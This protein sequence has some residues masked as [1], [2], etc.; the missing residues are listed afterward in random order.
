MMIG[1]MK[2]VKIA[3]TT[4]DATKLREELERKSMSK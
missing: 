1:L 3:F 4:S 2:T